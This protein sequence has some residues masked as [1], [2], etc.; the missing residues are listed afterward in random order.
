MPTQT[1]PLQTFAAGQQTFGPI[2]VS[3]GQHDLSIQLNGAGDWQSGA[4]GRTITLALQRSFDGGTT[5]L[6]Y[7]GASLASPQMGKAGALPTILVAGS[8]AADGAF[9]AR[10]LATFSASIQTGFLITFT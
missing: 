7:A 3:A 5:W 6:D 9:K 8:S 10:I 1:V 4:A 2:N